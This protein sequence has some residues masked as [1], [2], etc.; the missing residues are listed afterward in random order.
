MRTLLLFSVSLLFCFH[1]YSS[2]EDELI[3]FNGE[4]FVRAKNGLP[5][6][7]VF[8]LAQD[9]LGFIWAGTPAGIGILDSYAAEHYRAGSGPIVA[10]YSPGNLFVDN[11]DRIWVGTWGYGVFRIDSMRN[12][13][14]PVAL[15]NA[16]LDS[17]EQ[18]KIQTIAQTK[19]GDM[20]LGTF[21]NGL[22]QLTPN[23]KVRHYHEDA[24]S[25]NRILN[26]R[27]WSVVEDS[28]G[29]VW[30]G[31]SAGLNKINLVSE[32]I[33]SYFNDEQTSVADK[34]IRTLHPV[35]NSI[36]IG[37]NLGLFK[38]NVDNN[39]IT[40]LLPEEIGPIAVNRIRSDGK[41]GLW[42]AT[43]NGLYFYNT[44][45]NSFG[46][47][48]GN[49]HAFLNSQDI[50][51]V[52][53]T[54]DNVLILA[55]RFSGVVKLS[56][57]PPTFEVM[58][59]KSAISE[60]KSY[61][62][63]VARDKYNSLWAGTNNGLVKYN[64]ENGAREPLPT[65]LKPFEM[66]RITATATSANGETVW[67]GT[68]SDLHKYSLG[69]GTLQK[70]TDK[71]S[72]ESLNH[73][74]RI[75]FDSRGDKWVTVS[76]QG[77]FK[78]TAKG[79]ATHY[80]QAANDEF[81]IPNN[82][83]VQLVE[84]NQ[85][86]VWMVSG[87]LQLLR[88][89]ADSNT[90]E[91]V[92]F[93][94]FEGAE[95]SK[96]VATT[97][98]VS[99]RGNVWIG[100]YSGLLYLEKDSTTAILIRTQDGLSSSDVRSIVEDH[101]GH[102]WVGTGNG[103]TTFN[104]SGDVQK[105]LTEQDGLS[106]SSLNLRSAFHCGP[107]KLCFG[108]ESG[109][110]L[111]EPE[112]VAEST[113]GSD[114]VIT[115]IWINNLHHE[116]PVT[117]ADTLSLDLDS[118]SRNLRFRF[119]D[120]NHRPNHD[121]VLYFKMFGFEDNWNI[122]NVS[123]IANYTNLEP[124]EYIFKVTKNPQEMTAEQ[125]KA[126]VYINIIPPFWQ[127]PGT[128]LALAVFVVFFIAIFYRFRVARIKAAQHRLNKLVAMRTEN[129]AVLGA[130]GMEIT[131]AVSFDEIFEKLKQHLK[132]VLYGHKFMLG[133]VDE[134]G[135]QI[136][137]EL[138]IHEAEK[139]DSFCVSLDDNFHPAV[140]SFK[141]QR[142][143]IVND[144]TKLETA[145]GSDEYLLVQ[146]T[147][148][149]L[150]CIP[151]KVDETMIGVI[152]V[153]SIRSEAFVEYER[154]FLRTVAAYTAIALKNAQFYKNEKEQQLK[155][156]SWL[157][158]I[159]HY[160]NHEM[161]NA[162]LGAQTSLNMLS[163]KTDDKDLH[164]Y[165]GRAKR[166]HEEMRNIMKAVSNTTSMEAAIMRAELSRIDISRVV[167]TR[168]SEYTQI[169]PN[170]EFNSVVSPDIFIR[171][172]ADL[173]I[174]ALDKLVNNAVEHHA[175]G[176]EI[177]I[178]LNH[179]NNIAQLSVQNWGDQLPEDVEFIFGLFTSTKANAHEGNYGMGLYIAKLISDIHKGQISAASCQ[180][181]G[182]EGAIFELQF[183]LYQQSSDTG[184][185]TFNEIFN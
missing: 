101:H 31:T 179:I 107:T 27:V 181:Q 11:Q 158:N 84:D 157:E 80:H 182:K 61:I 71:L 43:F 95:E 5:S 133:I 117:G 2:P 44:T 14:V 164:K 156:I 152:F 104:D 39:E 56:L 52:L 108:T 170:I 135:N 97:L 162:I 109:I 7:T 171:G 9:K 178:Q 73:I 15:S 49:K 150:A 13:I 121:S 30:V 124:G 177:T 8:S 37:T 114:V 106:S 123:R 122:G 94:V 69:D 47:F 144:V 16:E 24:E 175:E 66:G 33:S 29:S 17:P 155:Q 105:I 174:Q 126:V 184:I 110:N 180:F 92:P 173:V 64:Y 3:R 6:D 1:S 77:I 142:E 143:L 22:Y 28:T 161:K 18:L 99:K 128:Q 35:D 93:E 63:S 78:L 113:E 118:D 147:C 141:Q 42:I 136:T 131:R 183:P 57:E 130:I 70:H 40:D 67:F 86:N 55:T 168:L 149:S 127:R 46:L 87:D 159:T 45:S 163:R 96:L 120:I 19:N 137:F 153:E 36:V 76:H 68:S 111:I 85:R 65:L 134:K 132:T 58:N 139:K 165:I 41:Q 21:D 166:S 138:V 20:W 169:Y 54:K 129:M 98:L 151:L 154:Q 83:V 145:I 48:D 23:G 116:E 4:E 125:Q 50:R 102:I 38:L 176:S 62:F 51:D 115:N 91:L 88:K 146:P 60:S 89:T 160:L 12:D 81:F 100:T 148:R 53:V 82:T 10:N 90:F 140:W 112:R 72:D 34:L 119:A 79:D 167:N 74:Q 172:N 185:D 59:A 75:Y 26:N 32:S 103:I 25:R